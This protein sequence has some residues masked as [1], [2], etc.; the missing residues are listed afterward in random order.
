MQSMTFENKN[1]KYV[2]YTSMRKLPM[3]IEDSILG[4][5]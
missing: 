4:S 1:N 5:D 2:G 3:T